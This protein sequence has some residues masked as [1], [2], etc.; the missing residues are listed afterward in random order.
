MGFKVGDRVIRTLYGITKKGI[1]VSESKWFG[2]MVKSL[3]SDGG[4]W[5]IDGKISMDVHYNNPYNF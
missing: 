1:I 3:E 5:E 2:Y 4:Y